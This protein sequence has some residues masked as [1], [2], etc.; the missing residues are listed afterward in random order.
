MSPSRELQ[1]RD[2]P[3]GV[4]SIGSIPPEILSQIFIA[5]A[6]PSE[7]DLN[8]QPYTHMRWRSII[9]STPQL[10][11]TF[12][13]RATADNLDTGRRSKFLAERSGGLLINLWIDVYTT[14]PE[15]FMAWWI[16]GVRPLL[17]RLRSINLVERWHPDAVSDQVREMLWQDL[18]KSHNLE[19]LRFRW[20]RSELFVWPDTATSRSPTPT[21]PQQVSRNYPS[22]AISI[23]S[24][25][26]S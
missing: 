6:T 23:P 19:M 12:R 1:P 15:D 8:A 25:S 5:T 20:V 22:N 21:L 13:I 3:D 24:H 4:A 16:E 10:W 18:A 14:N 26:G 7:A 9:N 17:H 2:G 11:R